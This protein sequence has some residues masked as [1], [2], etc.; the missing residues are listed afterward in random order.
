MRTHDNRLF[1]LLPSDSDRTAHLKL[2]VCLPYLKQGLLQSII[3]FVHQNAHPVTWQLDTDP[4]YPAIPN[5]NGT[6]DPLLGSALPCLHPRSPIPLRPI[7]IHHEV[8][9]ESEFGT[10][11]G[12]R[13]IGIPAVQPG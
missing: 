9:F 3:D 1:L 7:P 4:D 5:R 13:Q 12:L 6:T 2:Q 11:C 8:T 10:L